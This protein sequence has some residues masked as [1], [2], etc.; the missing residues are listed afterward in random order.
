MNISNNKYIFSLLLGLIFSIVAW[1]HILQFHG[2]CVNH[3]S[4]IFIALSFIFASLSY[5]L[6]S[7]L[8]SPV[9]H[10]IK[11]KKV[12]IWVLIIFTASLIISCTLAL[13]YPVH[14]LVITATGEK[15]QAAKGSEL[16]VTGL[17]LEDV[18]RV[19]ANDFILKGDWEIREGVPLSYKNQPA[20]LQWKKCIKNDAKLYL[21]RHPWSGIVDISWDGF[22]QRV[23]LYAEMTHADFT[24]LL[25]SDSKVPL[26]SRLV[27]YIVADAIIFSFFIVIAGLRF[28]LYVRRKRTK[29][30]I[31]F[32]ESV[33]KLLPNILLFLFTLLLISFFLEA[34]FSIHYYF[35]H[36]TL[37]RK[38]IIKQRNEVLFKE[39][40]SPVG[41]NLN[42]G[43]ENSLNL[44]P[45]F[46]YV[47]NSKSDNVNNF[48]F[49]CE[50]DFGINENGYYIKDLNSK[51][52]LIVGVFGGSFAQ[53]TVQHAGA[54]FQK[55]L[56]LLYPQK[57]PVVLNFACGGH[58]LPQSAF[59]YSYFRNMLH[60][61][62]FIDGLN[63]LWNYV[64]NNQMGYP[65]EYAKAGH[66][67]YKL[68]LNALTPDRFK[69]TATILSLRNKIAVAS[70]FSLLP[71]IRQFVLTHYVWSPLVKRWQRQIAIESKKL[72]KSF[73]KKK[74]FFNISN[75]KMLLIAAKQWGRYH[76]LINNI[77]VSEGIIDIH[78][79]QPNT[80]VPDSKNKWTDAEIKIVSNVSTKYKFFVVNG[81]PLLRNELKALEREGL[82]GKDLS[83]I[84]VNEKKT[85][86]SDWCHV[87]THG[88]KIV[89]DKV[90][91]LIETKSKETK[92]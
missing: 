24:M 7:Y 21:K 15:N 29:K 71:I 26:T 1:N 37:S 11:P 89:I 39:Y 78:A 33:R 81:Y 87:N 85:L 57:E 91:E 2:Y 28:V 6:I 52:V 70:Q 48:G 23:D 74:R 18:L 92:K 22:H 16:W 80:C 36:N 84:Y 64:E 27:I 86:W 44:H 43:W 55:Q 5:L 58:A 45:L 32:A 53:L 75:N 90:I 30:K 38:L 3:S 50:Y 88:S 73:G 34:I 35:K 41:R 51:N 10:T 47:Y 82:T 9:F 67:Q 42:R 17:L 12:L 79:I 31:T 49:L 56:Q 54:Y 13:T 61:A 69:K 68:S 20:T 14:S 77:S 63:E 60:V 4:I 83:Y 72:E 59:I 66:Y 40:G 62:V 25:S 19:D 65:P 8:I 46:G 76:Q